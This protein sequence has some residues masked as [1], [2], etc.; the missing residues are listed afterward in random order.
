MARLLHSRDAF[1]EATRP[2]LAGGPGARHAALLV[3]EIDDFNALAERL[4]SR[5]TD[6]IVAG[7]G[8]LLVAL[9]RSGDVVLTQPEGRFFV[10]L[11]GT[12]GEEGWTVGERLAM[13][14][15]T[16]G[17][18]SLD[19]AQVGR[20]SLSIG[21][22]ATPAH[23]T[24]FPA[25]YSAANAAC[26][27]IGT[28]GGDGAALAPLQHHDLLNRPL[29]IDRFAGRVDQ[30]TTLVRLLDEVVAGRPRV[31]AVLGESGLGTA[32][33]LRQIE[34]QARFR[35]GA[36]ITASSFPTAVREPY[37]VWATIV[38]GLHRLPEA[39]QRDWRELHKLVPE[40]GRRDTT[41]AA[42][43]QYR[44]L[45]ELTEYLHAAAAIRPL[46][47]VLDEMQWAD[48]T[49]WDALEHVMGRLDTERLL[50]C[51][52]CRNEREFSDVNDRRQIL[53]RHQL[54][55]EITLTRLTRDEVKQWL[56]AA[57]H[58]QEIGREF[59]AFIYRHTEG[60]PFFL[61]QL[62]SALLE[63][64]SL[65]H[66]GQ[67][68]EW[69]PVSELRLPSGVAGLIAQRLSRFSASSQTILT[70]AAILGRDF[71]VR[72]VVD[73]GAGSEPAVRLAMSEALGAG[74]IRPRS[75]RRAGGYAFRH[76]DVADSLLDSLSR[77]VLRELHGRVGS[78]LAGRGDRSAG[79]IAVHFHEARSTAFAYEYARK[80]AI[81]AEHLYAVNA[82]RAYLEIALHNA[83][84]A[85]ELAEVR[86][87]MA[88]LSEIVGRYD[89]VEELCDLVIEWFDGQ[90]DPRRSLSARRLRERARME[91]GQPA[92]VTLKTLQQ[93]GDQ[94]H[95]L[96]FDEER[97]AVLI[98][99][100]QTYSRLG[101]GR[102]AEQL[103]SEA[104]E[105]AERL[106]ESA[107]R[108]D[109]TL[110]LGTCLLTE[111]PARSHAV[112]AKALAIYESLG[113]IRGQA[114]SQNT[115]AIAAQFEGRLAEAHSA[116]TQ[117]IW[118][119]KLAGMPDVGGASALNLGVLI[120]KQGEFDRAREL[121]AESMTSFATVKNSEYQLIA[122]LNMAH[123]E[124]ELRS[125]ESAIELYSTTTALA[126]RIG[127][128]EVAISA[129][130]GAGLCQL[131]LGR[132][133]QA[134]ATSN[135]VG[136]L[137]EGRADWFQG[138]EIAE[139]LL[140]R[141]AA[142]DGKDEVALSRF[143]QALNLSESVDVYAAV[144]LTLACAP[145]LTAI[146]PSRVQGSIDRYSGTVKDL[147]YDELTKRYAAFAPGGR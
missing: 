126:E 27:R 123:C 11:P 63:Q 124:R 56:H 115:I 29:S 67:R 14:V 55:Q 112:I 37:A 44:L 64:G 17:L 42:G 35:G 69:S 70:T 6:A 117:A 94:A 118:M 128:G 76:G 32:T 66:T 93:L 33:L 144:W 30:V 5:T 73:A 80:A 102:M 77:E 38:R 12:T 99:A 109:A 127:Q 61:S 10:F 132:D 107:L 122:L 48:A 121:F 147:G 36:F 125:W 139:A 43:S 119:A 134:R 72:L 140:I 87:Q 52:S 116:F 135:E 41:Q 28:Q 113:D 25:L 59:L 1:D 79:E 78:A 114:R 71:D 21:V 98:L 54:Y 106:P 103:A 111:S 84:T 31:V 51:L 120:Q 53:R 60:N 86:M 81:E 82:G 143:E 83:T 19:R 16:Y 92:R 8:R 26:A 136:R 68:W 46:V 7:V 137:F 20:L 65:W 145:A 34:P 96:G 3:A 101:E 129:L 95:S 39:P 133:A 57:F 104:V 110:R 22:S 50:I 58:G 15:R 62:V 9:L 142:L 18:A 141:V 74:L 146:D 97:V 47:L 85:G 91:Q 4:G 89:E 40:L 108:A 100:S 130:A 45:E 88:H 13:A 2:I 131:E 90:D 105:M 23:G 24:A 49:S 138:R 75:D